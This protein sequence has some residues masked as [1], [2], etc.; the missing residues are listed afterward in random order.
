MHWCPTEY[1]WCPFLFA[2]APQTASPPLHFVSI[3]N[4]FFFC[5]IVLVTQSY[6]SVLD[7]QEGKLERVIRREN[8]TLP[9]FTVRGSFT[10]YFP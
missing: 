2:P 1:S 5:P 4:L 6:Y 8:N 3:I 10:L 9:C 7:N